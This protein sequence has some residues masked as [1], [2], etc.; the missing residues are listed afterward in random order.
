MDYNIVDGIC[1]WDYI[2]VIDFVDV[3]V[4]VLNVVKF[5]KMG[6]YNVVIGKGNFFVFI[7]IVMWISFW[8]M[9]IRWVKLII[10]VGLDG[11]F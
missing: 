5:G 2:Y 9:V 1:V 11:F 10:F 3:Y 8:W 4:K 7:Y 6:I